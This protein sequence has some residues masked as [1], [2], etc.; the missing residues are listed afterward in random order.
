MLFFPDEEKL[1]VHADC[2]QRIHSR[3]SERWGSHRDLVDFDRGHLESSR[4]ACRR[5]GAPAQAAP[6]Q[7]A[8]TKFIPCAR[9]TAGGYNAG[10]T[11]KR[12]R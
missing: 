3:G 12:C 5:D 8:L 2:S 11:Q 9:R 7:R 10:A 4:Q 1:A 6:A